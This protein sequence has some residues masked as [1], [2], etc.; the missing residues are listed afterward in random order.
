MTEYTIS[1]MILSCI[2]LRPLLR[3]I[4]RVA[5]DSGQGSSRT[6]PFSHSTK[7]FPRS[8][9]DR[10]CEISSTQH[11][12]GWRKGRSKGKVYGES[13]VEV[14]GYGSE[15]ELTELEM[16]RIYKTE[17]ISVTSVREDASVSEKER[18]SVGVINQ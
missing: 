2:S 6:K 15:V 13:G 18:V 10:K 3:K 14:N 9:T 5:T 7:G 4:Y 12:T 11:S 16:G 1:I 17:D 8:T